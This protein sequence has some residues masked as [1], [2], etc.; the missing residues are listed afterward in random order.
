MILKKYKKEKPPDSGQEVTQMFSQRNNPYC[1][2][3]SKRNILK[4]L[5][6]IQIFT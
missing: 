4:I 1:E 3:L 5:Y 6:N 2:F